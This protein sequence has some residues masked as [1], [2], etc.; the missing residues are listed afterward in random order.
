MEDEKLA[1]TDMWKVP[2]SLLRTVEDFNIRKDM[3][4]IDEL[5][6]SIRING[7]KVPLRGYRKDGLFFITA[8]HR[9][10]AACEK[11]QA[12]GVEVLVPFMV[13]PK[14]Y[15]VEQRIIDTFLTNDGKA[16]NPIEQAEGIQRLINYGWS[17][18][19]IAESLSKSEVY[20]RKLCSL[21]MAPMLLQNL[22]INGTISGTLAMDVLKD[23]KEA[24]D[25]LISLYDEIIVPEAANEVPVIKK[26]T[27]KDL[28]ETKFNSFK[29]FKKFATRPDVAIDNIQEDK[30]EA[31]NILL[32]II[33]NEI[34]EQEIEDYFYFK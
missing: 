29:S 13:E 8:G 10:F 9:R 32:K 6:E 1:K 25:K 19:Q 33:K 27:K 20:I 3:G 17:Y 31:F 24:I 2:V 23:G 11:L 26:I 21:K 16:L 7:V 4:N 15:S 28:V 22:V 14:A 5:T 12:D 34:T 30:K 18:K